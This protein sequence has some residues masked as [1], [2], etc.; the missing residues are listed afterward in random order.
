MYQCLPSACTGGSV[1]EG[2][3]SRARA[4]IFLDRIGRY[5]AAAK[6]WVKL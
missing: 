4:G 5:T 6:G 2:E 3:V 1:N